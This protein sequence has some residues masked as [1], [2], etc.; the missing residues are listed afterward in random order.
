V[1]DQPALA[2]TDLVAGYRRGNLEKPIVSTPSLQARRGDLVAVVGPNG[3]GK[4]TLLRTL[5]GSQPVLAG[6]V[7]LDGTPLDQLDRRERARRVAVV[8]TERVDAGLLSVAEVVLLGRHPHTGWSGRPE[9]GDVAIARQAAAQLGVDGSWTAPFA[10]LSDGQ[11]QRVLVARALAQE[12]AVLVLDEPTA[13]LDVAGRVEL[14]A[15]L[16]DLAHRAGLCVIA[17]TH[18]LDLALAHSDRVWL[19]DRGEVADDV[20]E[21]LVHDGRLG[22]AFDSA[23]V[24]FD[25]ATWAFR[26]RRRSGQPIAVA[27]PLLARLVVRL[28]ALPVEPAA[29]AGAWRVAAVEGGWEFS[30]GTRSR[31]VAT[32]AALSTTIRERLG[33]QIAPALV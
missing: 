25:V 22:R 10:E 31:R 21:A 11:R 7:F 28:G 1:S 17:S 13:Y 29:V 6:T 23:S 2:A 15:A 3:A 19:V 18:D 12:P 33:N 16:G 27:D 4:S 8:L 5:T 30:D 9:A 26:G 14:T 24:G 32:L 20:P